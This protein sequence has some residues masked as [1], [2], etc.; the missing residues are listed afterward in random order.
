MGYKAVRNNIEEHESEKINFPDL[1]TCTYKD[2][3]SFI[4]SC[5]SVELLEKLKNALLT[6]ATSKSGTTKFM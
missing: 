4:D 3:I 5:I 1:N 6:L 2:V